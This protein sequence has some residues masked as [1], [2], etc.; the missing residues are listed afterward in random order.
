MSVHLNRQL[1]MIKKGIL[2]LGAMVEESL[3]QAIKSVESRDVELAREI[4]V[5]DRDIDLAEIELEEECLKAL[6]LHQPVA[7]DLR[8]IIAVLKMNHDLER[9]GDLAVDIARETI[10][11]AAM[12]PIDTAQFHI[13]KM[14][15]YAQVMLKRSLDALVQYDPE[16]AQSVRDEDDTVDALDR[17]LLDE[18]DRLGQ[19]HP[20]RFRQ[21]VCVLNVS[22]HIERIADHAVNIAKDVIYMVRGNIVRHSSK[23]RSAATM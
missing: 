5:R 18:V 22:R 17:G 6:A 16:L 7:T 9:I 11:L 15:G 12:D 2:N 20:E 10:E 4:E 8:F 21:Y 14:F 19:Q 13:D 23:Q 1:D 3:K